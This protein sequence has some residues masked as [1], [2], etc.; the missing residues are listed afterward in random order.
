MLT[1]NVINLLQ[2]MLK[3]VFVDTMG[4]QYPVRGQSLSYDVYQN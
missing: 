3:Q 1:G 2:K 4:L